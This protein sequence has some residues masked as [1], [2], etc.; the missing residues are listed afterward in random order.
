MNEPAKIDGFT[1]AYI[2]AALWSSSDY[3]FGP[4]PC[5]GKDAVLSHYPEPEFDQVPMC[6]DPG[7]GVVQIDNPDPLDQHYSQSDIGPE[8]LAKMIA[9]CARFQSEQGDTIRAAIETGEVK[10]GPDFDEWG[11]AGHDFW[12]TR[13]GHGAGFWDGDWSEEA[14]EKLTEA[15]KAFG[16]FDLSV[17]SDGK[18]HH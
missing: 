12:L 4:C 17:G 5:C 13:E 1:Q 10:C 6:S 15:S 2:T 16:T 18:I 3:D 11:R 7:C 8:T 9:D 14:G